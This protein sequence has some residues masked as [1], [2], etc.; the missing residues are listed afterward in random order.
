MGIEKAELPKDEAQDGEKNKEPK[1][2]R[3]KFCDK[4][5]TRLGEKNNFCPKCGTPT[6]MPSNTPGTTDT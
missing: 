5:G 6:D 3:K 1:I 2:R 4:C